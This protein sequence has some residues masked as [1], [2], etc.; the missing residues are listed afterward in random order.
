MKTKP[1]ILARWGMSGAKTAY[2]VHLVDE[3]YSRVVWFEQDPQLTKYDVRWYC[4][5]LGRKYRPRFFRKPPAG[6][7]RC[8]RCPEIKRQREARSPSPWINQTPPPF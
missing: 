4:S 6:I 7:S 1:K 8:A 3:D 5:N 2:R